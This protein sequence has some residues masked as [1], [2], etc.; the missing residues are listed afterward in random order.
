MSTLTAIDVLT[1]RHPVAQRRW[2]VKVGIDASVYVV[3]L[4]LAYLLRFDGVPPQPH[5]TWMVQLLVAVPL[6]RLA[7]GWWL[8][9]HRCSWRLF[10]LA[11]A[12]VVLRSVG[13]VSAALL[14]AR[15]VLPQVSPGALV[16]PLGVIALE[17]LGAAAAMLAVRIGTRVLDERM[18]RERNRADASPSRRRALLIGAGRA[19]RMAVRELRLRP[20]A[21]FD[22]VGFLDDD[23]TR[24]GQ[25]IEGVPVLGTTAEAA[26]VARR[27]GAQDLVLTIPAASADVRQLIAER[28]KSTGLPLQ[29]VPG[30]YELISG[31][32]GI[33]RIR[34]LRTEE[35]LGRE[36][37]RLDDAARRR[38]ARAFVGKR[39]VVTGAG[40]SIGSELC[41]QL[42]R[43]EPAS[44][45]LLE[46]NENNLFDIE[47]EMRGLLGDRAVPCLAD[48][49][50]PEQVELAFAR[51]R[52]EV[53]VHAAAY[54]HVPMMELHP[55][56][57]VHNNVRGTRV[58]VEAAHRQGVGRFV[59]VSTDK[60]VNPTSVMGASK[61]VAELVLHGRAKTSSMR[62]CAVRFGN[63]LGSRG[64]VLHTFQ[65]QIER[66]GPVTVTHPEVTRFFMTIPEAVRLLLQAAAI[67]E[68][69]ETFLLEMGESVRIVD[70]ARRMISLAGLTEHEVPIE[71]VGLR[72]GEK[73]Y[74]ELLRHGERA[75]DSGVAGILLARGAGAEATKV[76]EQIAAL[77]HAGEVRDVETI[78]AMLAGLTGYAEP[79]HAAA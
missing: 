18:H 45:V 78:R 2:L 50:D 6:L 68:G 40:G 9:T 7:I 66:G 8:G 42:A 76:R 79:P 14:V 71:F 61:R 67:G 26:E 10:G 21:G 47:Q 41:R 62:S 15:L 64:S 59:L 70:V 30:L 34:P 39:I 43:L 28:C 29:T 65:R 49:A 53:V 63:V 17:G 36:V 72:P 56:A 31:K 58:V 38:V 20:D 33:T 57:A 27:V 69:G 23:P 75:C 77:E 1:R 52:P 55:E 11:E 12:L 16:V 22:P 60:A 25:R 13:L 19:G 4:L 74:E 73:L 37:V 54:K 32:V 44:L 51:H 5:L 46:R 3:A 48:V 35:L 24:R